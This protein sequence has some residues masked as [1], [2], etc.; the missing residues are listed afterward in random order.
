MAI[1]L[2]C[3]I[4]R[5]QI[6]QQRPPKSL[7]PNTVQPHRHAKVT[8][9]VLSR[10]EKQT[11]AGRGGGRIRRNMGSEGVVSDRALQQRGDG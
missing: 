5:M 9:L 10:V 2:Q 1:Q 3:D 11:L 8:K 6:K 4:Q 7:P